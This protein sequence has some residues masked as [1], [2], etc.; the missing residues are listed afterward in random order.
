[1]DASF[2]NWDNKP[3][4]TLIRKM[5]REPTSLNG[6][7]T[8]EVVIAHHNPKTRRSLATTLRGLGHRVRATCDSTETLSEA[9]RPEAPD[10]IIS[11]VEMPDGNAI[12]KL[13]AISRITP[14]PAIVV[15]PRESLLHVEEALRDHVMAYL[16]EPIDPAQVKPTIYLVCERFKQ[17]ELLKS[18]NDDLRQAL[19]DRKLIERAKGILMG[20]HEVGEPEAFRMLQKLAQSKRVKLRRI[21]AAV[22]ESTQEG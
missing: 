10:L 21:A 16:V 2:E 9:C 19:T 15:T 11:G 1:M 14:T 7:E 3:A 5:N 6:C 8:I 18:E 13:V 17:F 4:A 12:D 22:I 20:Q